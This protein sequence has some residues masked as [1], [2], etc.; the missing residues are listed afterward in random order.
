MPEKFPLV[1]LIFVLEITLSLIS[2]NK[3]QTAPLLNPPSS[4]ENAPTAKSFTPLPSKSP[5]SSIETPKLSSLSRVPL[6][7]PLISLIF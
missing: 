6:K 1:S 2:K 7:L 5:I 3:I 4:S